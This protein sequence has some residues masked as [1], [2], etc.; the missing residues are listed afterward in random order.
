MNIL[1]IYNNTI[2]TSY[3]DDDDDDDDDDE[4]HEYSINLC[5]TD[6]WHRT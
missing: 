1:Q 6:I 4:L 3:D 5:A 2:N